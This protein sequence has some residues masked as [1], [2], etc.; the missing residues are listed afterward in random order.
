MKL[1]TTTTSGTGDGATNRGSRLR[2]GIRSK[3][4]LPSIAV[5]LA[6]LGAVF[7]GMNHEAAN[8][9]GAQLEQLK[10]SAHSI[11]D[12]IDRNLFERYGDVQAFARNTVV[13]RD[14]AALSDED[15]APIVATLNEY[16]RLYG[17][18]PVSMVL[19]PAGSVVAVNT[20]GPDGAPV[21]TADAVSGS[22]FKD[23][24]WF[25]DAVAGR[26]T[27][28]EGGASGTVMTQPAADPLVTA[29]YGKGAPVWTM[30]FA[31][32]IH[33]ESGAV[34]G[35]WANFFSGDVVKEIIASQ[36]TQM[37]ADG[38]VTAQISLVDASGDLLAELDPS[39]TGSMDF[40][41]DQVLEFNFTESKVPVAV[42]AASSS[43]STGTIVAVNTRKSEAAGRTVTQGGGFAKSVPILGYPGTGFT[44]FVRA[45]PD[46]I[47]ATT[48]SLRSTVL[49]AALGG[50]VLG[51]AA[52]LLV[53]RPI[54][55]G[56]VRV[57]D[58]IVGLSNGEIGKDVPV[59]STD[60][61]GA[62]AKAFNEARAGLYGVFGV[63]KVDWTSIGEQ[64]RA[65]VRLA[66]GLKQTLSSVNENSQALATA[67][68]ELTAVSQQ[69]SA[70]SEETAAQSDVVASAA[71]QVS[72]NV[73][74]VATSA[75]EI[76]ASVRE[77]AK[78][79]SESARVA[80]EAV[81]VANDTNKIIGRL[82]ES[83]IEIGNVIKV[84]TSIAQQTNLLALNATIEAARAGEAGKGFAVVAN[85]VKELAKQTAQATEEISQKIQAIQT[86]TKGAVGA[87]DQISTVIAKINDISNTIASAVEEQSATT[88]EIARN[89]SEAS[90]GSSEISKNIAN[91]SIA[92]RNTT[93]GANNTLSA[94]TELAKLAVS[95]KDVVGRAKT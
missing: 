16:V 30:V 51:V 10:A 19:D 61:V 38:I 77:I 20:V 53:T 81:E 21:N 78:S 70:N 94:A 18:Y 2:L 57:K 8:I 74:T 72:K 68:E 6:S 40:I 31:A 71:E 92:A 88:S 87:I 1:N 62:M 5:L 86:D 60:E 69:M 58:V 22:G 84:I 7:V 85:E 42:A 45:S 15:R 64:Q 83:S 65:A 75:E 9:E 50:L 28:V 76:S 89:A 3:I 59:Q 44:T 27:T 11:Q 29:V 14:L 54:V 55:A 47:F 33:D 4:I 67:S 66:E 41:N 35:V 24:A 49:M 32:P 12:K 39:T 43:N 73:A 90:A 13:H 23:E 56:I 17:V 26:F 79:A 82:G 36:Y 91:V 46:E 93:Q 95:L 34:R 37:K 48:A 25:K 52:L 80:S 63:E